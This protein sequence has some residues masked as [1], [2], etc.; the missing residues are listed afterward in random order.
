MSQIE[1]IRDSMSR[2]ESSISKE[3]ILCVCVC[4]YRTTKVIAVEME[5]EEKGIDLRE[6]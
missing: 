6:I 4:V 5:R 1:R 3:G 2:R